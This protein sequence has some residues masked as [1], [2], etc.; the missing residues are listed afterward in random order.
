VAVDA[1]PV[2]AGELA[3]RLRAGEPAVVGRVADGTLLLDPRTMSDGEV[4]AAA[5]AAAA[6]IGE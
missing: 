4:E 5:A 2:G 6:A 1:G 3:A